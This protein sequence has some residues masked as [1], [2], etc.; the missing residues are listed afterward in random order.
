MNIWQQRFLNHDYFV[1]GTLFERSGFYYRCKFEWKPKETVY[2]S[3]CTYH[4]VP[5]K[6]REWMTPITKEEFSISEVLES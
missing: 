3:Y 5:Y 1:Y 2:I 4:G 6:N